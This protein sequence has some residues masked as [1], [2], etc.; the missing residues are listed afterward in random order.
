M[1]TLKKH[2]AKLKRVLGV[3]NLFA[4]GYGDLGASIFYSLGVTAL[5]SL[6]A[7]PLSLG[8]AGFVFICTALSYAELCSMFHDSGGSA[9]FARHALNDFFGFIAGWG[10]LLDYI[11][12]IAISAF[13]VG[14][15]L[16]YFF[17]VLD[18]SSAQ[19]SCGIGIIVFLFLL[20]IRGVKESTKVSI[21]LTAGILLIEAAIIAIGFYSVIEISDLSHH[22]AI[23]TAAKEYVPSWEGFWKGTAM[24]MVA[25]TGIEAIAQLGGESKKPA[26]TVPRS[27]I[28][29]MIVVVVVYLGI[30]FVALSIVSPI[31]LGTKY[32]LNP[33]EAV[34]QGLPF[35]KFFLAPSTAILA[36]AILFVSANA[37]LIGASRV[38]FSMGEHYQLPRFFYQVNQRFRTPITALT[39]FSVIACAIVLVSRAQMS[40]LADLYNF[41]AMI[42][43]LSTHVALIVLRI[44]KPDALRP[45]RVGCNFSFR[46][47]KIPVTAVIGALATFAVWCLVLITKPAGRYFG[48][49]WM[50]VGII[51]YILYRRSQKMR[52]TR[53]S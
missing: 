11:A 42:A 16:D 33:F 36:A 38:A 12:T 7:T 47:A 28:L 4:I 30:A 1:G 14:P 18:T 37:G 17:P 43:F 35:G 48:V 51:M 5:F 49:A 34:V 52:L 24:A 46:G 6:G 40:F 19:I 32:I 9:S 39:F 10:L 45:F 53:A 15:Y 13:A 44:K 50:I 26:K 3:F 29:T 25:Y 23:G 21:V 2:S 31:E 8:L 20:N 41:G 22:F 27:I